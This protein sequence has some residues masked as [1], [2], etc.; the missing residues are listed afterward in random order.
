[1]KTI[2]TSIFFTFLTLA[3]IVTSEYSLMIFKNTQERALN[4][5]FSFYYGWIEQEGVKHFFIQENHITHTQTQEAGLSPALNQPKMSSVL[6]K[7]L[8]SV[9]NQCKLISYKQANIYK[10]L[11]AVKYA[12]KKLLAN[13]KNVLTIALM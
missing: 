4:T 7:S 5:K 6:E 8:Q 12:K 11:N 1:M 2:I 13:K 3:S 10:S 9:C